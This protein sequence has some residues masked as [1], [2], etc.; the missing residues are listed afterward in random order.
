MKKSSTIILS[1]LIGLAAYSQTDSIRGKQFQLIGKIKDKV[2]M[3]PHCGT[4]AWGTVVEFEV[5]NLTGMNYS[6]TRIGIIVTC[7]EFYKE[8]FFEKDKMYQVVFSDKNQAN[9]EW[10]IPN[11]DSLRKNGLSFDPY[12]I[13]LKKT[14]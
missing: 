10:A 4:I 9:F 13:S 7:P 14:P 8:E 3:P 2:L 1:L 11:K 12:A 5:V 6:K